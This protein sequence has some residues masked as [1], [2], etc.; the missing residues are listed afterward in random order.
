MPHDPAGGAVPGQK[1]AAGGKAR[2]RPGQRPRQKAVVERGDGVLRAR[3]QGVGRQGVGRAAGRTGQAHQVDRMS[4]IEIKLAAAAGQ[5]GCCFHR[6]A[7]LIQQP[8]D[9]ER[10]V[11]H[12]LARGAGERQRQRLAAACSEVAFEGVE[13]GCRRACHRGR[14]IGRGRGLRRDGCCKTQAGRECGPNGAKRLAQGAQ[15]AYVSDR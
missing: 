9:A 12:H 7:R 5:A 13:C 2:N 6:I 4:R 14:V 8:D 1:A 10:R 15:S 3:S 11:E